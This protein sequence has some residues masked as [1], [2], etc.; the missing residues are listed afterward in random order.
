MFLLKEVER[1]EKKTGVNNKVKKRVE[2]KD[3]IRNKE[4]YSQPRRSVP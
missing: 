4:R 2:K 3:T 1:K